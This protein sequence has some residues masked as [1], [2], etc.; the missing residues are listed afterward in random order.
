M[1]NHNLYALLQSKFPT[2]ADSVFIETNNKEKLYYRELDQATAQ[3]AGLLK[4]LGVDKGERVVVQVDKSPQAVLLYLACLRRGA[5]YV[6]LN[7]AYT[8]NEVSYFLG[9]AQP[10]VIVCRP[11]SL[12][13]IQISAKE[14]AIPHTLTLGADGL[15][16]LIDSAAESEIDSM[17]CHCDKHDLAAESI[18]GA[19]LSG[20]S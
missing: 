14:F 1:S 11:D 6:P 15:G 17:V 3:I 9:D 19:A 13:E 4:S 8:T 5:V 16:T 20:L 12:D 18:S 2:K 10:K 7:T